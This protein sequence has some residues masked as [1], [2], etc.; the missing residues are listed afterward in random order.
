MTHTYD[1]SQLTDETRYPRA[2]S[3][4]SESLQASVD[5]LAAL[6]V[7][8]GQHACETLRELFDVGVEMASECGDLAGVLASHV[9]RCAADLVVVAGWREHQRL[10]QASLT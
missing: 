2:L 3:T 10:R 1:W 5:R 6:A 9:V 7:D 8:D 4:T